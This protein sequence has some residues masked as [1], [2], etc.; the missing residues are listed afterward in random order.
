MAQSGDTVMQT[1]LNK[2][3]IAKSAKREFLSF[4]GVSSPALV[5]ITLLLFLPVA[6]LFWLSL[7]NAEG[8]LSADNYTR[9]LEPIYV[10]TFI[11][12]FKVSGLVTVFCILAGY[13]LAYFIAQTSKRTASILM[14]FVL[15]PFWTSLLV[16]TYAWLVLLQRKGIINNFL[17]DTGLIDE[18]LKLAHNMTGTVI[19]MSH[20]MLPFLIL[21]LYGTMTTIDKNLMRAA[22]NCGASPTKAFWQVYFPLS[23]PG[24]AA[25]TT[26]VFVL[27]LGFY[28]TPE[29]LG[30]GRV[31]MWAMRIESNIG[32][33]SNWGSASSL[34]VL[35]LVVTAIILVAL[36][37]IFR[38]KSG[39]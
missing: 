7:F 12:T 17:I 27:C 20:I 38:V 23:L 21:P 11:T 37:K 14:M 34:G 24:L 35:L 28:V 9:L 36:G 4:L 22:S 30:G 2:D 5:L 31:Q 16:R 6:G 19:G 29:L 39:Q 8:Q 33:Y 13:P 1:E 15:L 26:L 25:G 18:P 10:K 32:L 3:V